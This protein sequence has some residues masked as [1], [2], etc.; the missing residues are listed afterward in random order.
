MQASYTVTG[1][2]VVLLGVLTGCAPRAQFDASRAPDWVTASSGRFSA[3]RYFQGQ[4]EAAELDAAVAAARQALVQAVTISATSPSTAL[5]QLAEQAEVVDLWRDP[6][7]LI[8]H[9]LVVLERPRVADILHQQ[10]AQLAQQGTQ[11]LAAATELTD[12]LLQIAATRQAL[13]LQERRA[14]VLQALAALGEAAPEN[15]DAWSVTELQAHLKSLLGSIDIRPQVTDG[16]AIEPALRESLNAAGMLSRGPQSDYV[17]K[18]SL[19]RS[20]LAW[21]QGWFTRQGMLHVELVDQQGQVRGAA[22]WPLR[23]QAGE[24]EQVDQQMLGL[25]EQTLKEEL[26]ETVLGFAE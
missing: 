25:V 22:Q 1:I 14:D 20:A 7:T 24:R 18:S 11:H 6:D 12:P 5:E 19:Q 4:G 17:L 2:L 23:A 3:E 15:L 13:A 21:K 9:V 8:H 16:S 26:R 10:L